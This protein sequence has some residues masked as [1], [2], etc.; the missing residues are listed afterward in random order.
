MKSAPKHLSPEAKRIWKEILREYAIDDA[1]G[2][3]I[4][5]TALEAWDRAQ[6][7]REVIEQEGMQ[8]V[9]RFGQSKAHPLLAVERDA[10]AGFLQGMKA[11][12][13]DIE[14]LRDGK[15]RPGGK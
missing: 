5:R 9:D 11:L 4:L 15:G 2:L 6:G 1:A 3:R 10:R 13:L 12:N 8:I 14:P 7:A